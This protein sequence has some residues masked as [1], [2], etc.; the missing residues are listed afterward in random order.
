MLAA[1]SV[2]LDEVALYRKIHGLPSV[3]ASPLVFR[4]AVPRALD[5]AERLGIPLTFFVVSSD[6][7]DPTSATLMRTAISIGHTVESHSATHPYDLIRL[8]P[9]AIQREVSG[10]FDAIEK[11][12]GARPQGFRAPGY[13]LSDEVLDAVEATQAKFDASAFPCPAYYLAKLAVMGAMVPLGRRSSSIVSSPVQLLAPTE[14]YRPG[15][16]WWRK[17]ARRLV[18]IPMRVTSG[19]RLP[20]IGTT[21]LYGGE[22]GGPRLIEKCGKPK[23]F[24]LELHGIDFLEPDDGVADLAKRQIEIT[25][26]LAQRIKILTAC[27]R[28]LNQQGY[29]FVSLREMAA[30]V[31]QSQDPRASAS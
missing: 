18:E 19:M 27:V 12:L 4:K 21:L 13:S 2:D 22:T 8:G 10:S 17:G 31:A 11:I 28:R 7:E 1:I 9:E 3:D 15:K 16:S 14:P 30:E 24:S 5:L 6:L 25:R 29:R 23:H 20:V 26:P